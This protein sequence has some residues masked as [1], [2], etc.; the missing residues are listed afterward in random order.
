M[1]HTGKLCLL[2]ALLLSGAGYSQP[3]DTLRNQEPGF[4]EY[5]AEELS[6]DAGTELDFSQWEDELEGLKQDPVNLNSPDEHELRRLPLINE[7]QIQNLLEYTLKYG[8]L[9]SIYELQFIEGFNQPVIEQLL[10]FITLTVIRQ[11]KFKWKTALLKGRSEI[12]LKY[13]RVLDQQ[14]GFRKVSDSLRTLN[15]GNYYS[16]SPDAFSIRYLYKYKDRLQYGFVAEKDAGETLLK[17]SGSRP[18]GFDFYSAHLYL[19][20]LGRISYLVVGDYHLQFG[21]GLTLWTG[22]SM[23]KSGGML[24]QRKHA[25]TVRPHASANET[26]FMRGAAATVKFGKTGLTGF[27]SCRS[28]DASL[29]EQDTLLAD[30]PEIVSILETGYHRTYNELNNRK[31]VKEYT[32]GG[33]ASFSFNRFITGITICQTRYTKALAPES[34]PYSKFQP[35]GNSLTVA[36]WDYG[37]SFKR[38]T[39]YGETSYRLNSGLAQIHGLSFS[40]DPKLAV[41]VVFRNYPS[42]YVN[43]N[44]ASFGGGQATNEN[45]VYLGISASISRKLVL[46]AYTDH[47][48]HPW[49]SYRVDAP[50][51]GYEYSAGLSWSY[52]ARGFMNFR[53]RFIRSPQNAT[54]F[55]SGVR[56]IIFLDR[57]C[58]QWQFRYQAASWIVFSDRIILTGVIKEGLRSTGYCFSQEIQV[59]PP[60]KPGWSLYARYAWFDTDSY[61]A[62]IY[63]YEN[64]LPASFSAPALSGKGSRVCLM[65][66]A[67]LWKRGVCWVKYSGTFYPG[68]DQISDGPTAIDG[69]RKREISLMVRLRF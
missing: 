21:Q 5:Y 12:T 14:E 44:G 66:R 42:G 52:S 58:W 36:G 56:P 57:D 69:N 26:R 17:R 8:Q 48:R 65:I 30:D 16:G 15:P 40:P 59:T 32:F 9:Y 11:E 24:P 43:P 4:M 37:F 68:L 7:Q 39:L 45:G 50:S 1:N 18:A 53:Y 34:T 33:H 20:D 62:R 27:F 64:G 22:F 6:Q 19:S 60:A 51:T 3:A 28:R 55:E 61:D 25:A 13:Q 2:T 41:S 29:T 67:D 49:L 31:T 38:L 35:T 10:P 63:A 46:T 47:F 54:T 23:G